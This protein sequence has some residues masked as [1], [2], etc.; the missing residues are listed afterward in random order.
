MFLQICKGSVHPGGQCCSLDFSLAAISFLFVCFFFLIFFLFFS[1]SFFLPPF[2]TSP[3]F[4]FPFPYILFSPLCFLVFF[5]SLLSF[6]NFF[7]V[8]LIFLPFFFLC[9]VVF[10][11][12]PSFSP[13]TIPS[14]SFPLQG[15]VAAE[16]TRGGQLLE[17]PKMLPFRANTFSLQVSIQ[18][19]PQFLWSIKPFTTCQVTMATRNKT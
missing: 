13:F 2:H 17:E 7:S 8:F 12:L 11:F 3:S 1:D 4:T 5:P 6:K 9:T 19:V 18:D 15:V 10:H 14:L 16:K